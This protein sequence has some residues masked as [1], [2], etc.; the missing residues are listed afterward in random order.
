MRRINILAL[1]LALISLAGCATYSGPL[2]TN[3]IDG[4]CPGQKT[5]AQFENCINTYWYYPNTAAGQGNELVGIFES[6]MDLLR[7]Y[8]SEGHMSDAVAIA[9]S[10]SLAYQLR[11][12]ER[13]TARQANY[14]LMQVL[15]SAAATTNLPRSQSAPTTPTSRCRRMGDTSGQIYTFSRIGCPFGYAPAL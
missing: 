2:L 14:Q 10:R 12:N 4:Y 3:V 9:N 5:F 7:I 13:A 6:R 1:S 15:S 11:A 8:V